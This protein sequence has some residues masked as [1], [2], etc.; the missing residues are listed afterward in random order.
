MRCC[1]GTSNV[2][3]N[4]SYGIISCLPYQ[5]WL[6][7]WMVGLR[8]RVFSKLIHFHLPNAQTN[9]SLP[10]MA[11]DWLPWKS[12]NFHVVKDVWYGLSWKS[13]LFT[14][15][16][17][18]CPCTFMDFHSQFLLGVHKYWKWMQ[19]KETNLG[20]AIRALPAGTLV[21]SLIKS[22]SN[23]GFWKK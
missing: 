15:K 4:S 13:M 16:F 7:I 20:N 17:H 19:Y 12:M 9:R 3:T 5:K 21:P 8:H 6:I 18:G 1:I 11:N 2:V 10:L 14:M 23:Y 22:Q